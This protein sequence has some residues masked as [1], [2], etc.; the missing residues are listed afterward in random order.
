VTPTLDISNSILDEFIEA[1]KS[2]QR[3]FH[4]NYSFVTV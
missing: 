2:L 1:I 3:L 4:P